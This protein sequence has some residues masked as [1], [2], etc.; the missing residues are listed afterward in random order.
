MTHDL[1]NDDQFLE[2]LCAT[3]TNNE[4]RIF[5]EW[6]EE[7]SGPWNTLRQRL[8]EERRKDLRQLRHSLAKRVKKDNTSNG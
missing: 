3:L 4:E 7:F 8:Q 5:R 6:T 2:D 1:K